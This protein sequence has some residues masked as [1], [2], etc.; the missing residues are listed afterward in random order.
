M[1]KIYT[2]SVFEF[3]KKTNSCKLNESE[4]EFYYISDDAP[5]AEMKGKS[6]KPQVTTTQHDPWAPLV[7]YLT[8][9]LKEAQAAFLTDQ[10]KPEFSPESIA[11]QQA[12]IAR[13]QAGNPLLGQAQT[14]IGKTVAGDYL[15]GGPGF[16]AA[17]NA[18]RNKI[19]PDVESRFAAGGRGGSGLAK[20]AEASALGDAFA[21]LYG[22]E[23]NRMLAGAEMAPGLAK[24]DYFDIAK[25]SEVGQQKEAMTEAQRNE[26]RRMIQAYLNTITGAGGNSGTAT[27]M[28]PGKSKPNPWMSSLGGGLSGG[29]AGMQTGNPW[30]AGVGAVGGGLLGLLNAL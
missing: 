7:P 14:E 4:S 30:L 16:D 24:A 6:N 17:Y 2:K 25:L 22:Q 15:Y 18:A 23:R 5:I 1:R 8:S 26:R 11:A 13:A 12:Q 9:G 19:I 3:D 28:E 21:G 20:T 29:V 27:T 10:S